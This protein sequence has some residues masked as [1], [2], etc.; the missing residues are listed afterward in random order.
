VVLWFKNARHSLDDTHPQR[1]DCHYTVRSTRHRVPSLSITSC[2]KES[3]HLLILHRFQVGQFPGSQQIIPGLT[4]NTVFKWVN[5]R[6]FKQLIPSVGI[7]SNYLIKFA[8]IRE[9]TSNMS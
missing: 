5:F 9:N 8:G 3:D 7:T 2:S 4:T 6:V 1:R